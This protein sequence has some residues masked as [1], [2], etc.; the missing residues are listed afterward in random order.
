MASGECE[1]SDMVLSVFAAA[2]QSYRW[3]TVLRPFPS[4]FV[5]RDGN[6]EEEKDHKSLVDCVH[7][8]PPLHIAPGMRWLSSEK[9]HQRNS[10]G[11]TLMLACD[12]A[13][14]QRQGRVRRRC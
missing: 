2:L 1:E 12:A 3:D 4:A 7:R 14:E 8:L 11:L 10:G 13:D 5:T 6:G 9:S